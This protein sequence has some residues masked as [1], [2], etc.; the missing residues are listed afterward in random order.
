MNPR[1][2]PLLLCLAALA[3]ASPGR[4]SVR[5]TERSDRV[6]AAKGVRLV[7]VDNPR[8]DV[9]VTPSPDG[10]IHVTAIKTCRGR[11]KAEARRFAEGIVVAAG[12]EGDRYVVRATYPRRVDV[13]ISFWDLFS[14]RGDTCDLGLSHEL[15]LLVRVPAA[16]QVRLTSASG[17]LAAR[18]LAGR[19]AL[20]SASG[21]CTVESAGGAVEARTV[22]GDVRIGGPARALVRT[23]S[24]DVRAGSPGPLD[25]VTASGDIEVAGAADS[26][27]LASTSGDISVADAPRGLSASSVSGSIEVRAAG[28]AVELRSTSGDVS[29]RLRAPLRHAS[30]STGSGSIRLGLE[31]GLDASLDLSTG[32]GEIDCDLPVVLLGHGRQHMSAK[33]G[34]GGTT[35]KAQTGSGDL[36]VTGGGR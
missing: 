7:E 32:A 25:A 34:R 16:L 15:R 3:A 4:A 2:I 27:V 20:Q 5:H 18:G 14:G 29:A 1:T 13:R 10:F 31:P 28:G 26:L 23:T 36:H 35:V 19:Q 33:Y 11:D 17:D 30:V 8:G 12:T 21:D 9:V 24:G 6:A 22:S